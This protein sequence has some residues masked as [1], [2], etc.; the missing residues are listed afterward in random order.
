MDCAYRNYLRYVVERHE[1]REKW[2]G[3]RHSLLHGVSEFVH[4]FSLF[5]DRFW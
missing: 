4:H 5:L 3:E 2:L 1:F